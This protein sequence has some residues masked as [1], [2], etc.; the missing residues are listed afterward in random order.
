MP[1]YD[2]LD[3]QTTDELRHRAFEVAQHRH[4]LGF[5][6]DLVK[7]LPASAGIASEDGS[8]GN[9]VGSLAELVRLAH[10]LFTADVATLGDSEPLIRE[11]FISYLVEHG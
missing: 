7:H 1:T 2:E 8:P 3:A 11:R 9:I 10:E 5:F 6:W 4:D